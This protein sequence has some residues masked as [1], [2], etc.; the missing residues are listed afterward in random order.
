M[1][2][3]L[4]LIAILALAGPAVGEPVAADRAYQ[5]CLDKS[6]GTNPAWA[7]CGAA[8]VGREDAGL[9]AEWKRIYPG[10]A[11]ASKAALLEEQRLWV[12]FREKACRLYTTG[13]RG[14]E[15]EVLGYFTCLAAVIRART[16]ELRD[17][18]VEVH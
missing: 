12:A 6:D 1:R 3:A 14:R 5:R 13:D 16:D 17:Y 8:L 15:G 4:P 10:E 7:A 11:S 9:N 2:I 18:R